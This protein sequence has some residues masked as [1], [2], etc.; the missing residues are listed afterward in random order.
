M[1]FGFEIKGYRRPV[2]ATRPGLPKQ[3]QVYNQGAKR[4][5][6]YRR[7]Q[8]KQKAEVILEAVE[9]AEAAAALDTDNRRHYD[10][11]AARGESTS[12]M[13]SILGV[14]P[15]CVHEDAQFSCTFTPLCW[16]HGGVAMNGCDSM[17]YSCCVSHTIAQTQG[18]PSF[19][20]SYYCDLMSFCCKMF[21]NCEPKL[22]VHPRPSADCTGAWP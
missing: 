22:D 7:P 12:L 9:T 1:K 14:N 17:L 15:F 5:R 21:I 3:P 8:P 18:S 16:M 2:L 13:R 20:L 10:A 11:V 6:A 4:P 19:L